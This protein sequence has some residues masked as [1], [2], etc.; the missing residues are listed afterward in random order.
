MQDLKFEDFRILGWT[1]N[2]LSKN[3]TTQETS[4]N[5]QMGSLKTKKALSSKGHTHQSA[6]IVHRLEESI[7]HGHVKQGA[8]IQNV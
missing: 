7:G 4:V 1:R 6:E 8:D 2:F 3:L 5:R